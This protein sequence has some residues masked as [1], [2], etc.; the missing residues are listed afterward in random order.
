MTPAI[1]FQQILNQAFPNYTPGKI[2]IKDTDIG[3]IISALL[4]YI[5]A[6]SG[7]ILFAFLIMGGFELLTSGGNPE[8]AKKA[9]GRITSALIGFLIIFLAYWITQLL[10][11]I[12][13]ISIF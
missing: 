9:Q 1:N 12:F 5:F 13:G 3:K 8:S 4:P 11:V 2:N 7:L 6:I 10:E